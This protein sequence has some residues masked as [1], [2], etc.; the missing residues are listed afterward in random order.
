MWSPRPIPTHLPI[1]TR[2]GIIN[3]CV[4]WKNLQD[5]P[6]RPDP[7]RII[8]ARWRF[9]TGG[10]VDSSPA[11][12][13]DGTVYVG[14]DDGNLYAIDPETGAEVWRFP[15]GGEIRSSPAV[16]A[17]GPFISVHGIPFMP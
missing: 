14:S 1:L 10:D 12:G 4:P 9:E 17:D 15:A 16:G 7:G 6:P 11:I 2:A 8:V 5:L 3:P 13:A